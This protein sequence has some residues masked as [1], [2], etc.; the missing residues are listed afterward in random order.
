MSRIEEYGKVNPHRLTEEQLA[1]LEQEILH[2][3]KRLISDEYLDYRFWCRGLPSRQECFAACLKEKYLPPR[4]RRILEVG[5]GR[6][7]GLSRLLKEMGHRMTCMDPRAEPME[8][9]EIEVRK[10][11]FLFESA[12]LKDFD[13][14]VAQEPC[15]GT[16]HI[17]RACISQRVPFVIVLCGVPHEKIGGGM[18]GDVYEWYA[19]LAGIAPAHTELEY[20]EMY[21]EMGVAVIRSEGL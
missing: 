17:V 11:A 4:K 14:V 6:Y 21:P 8:D 16:E 3:R 20:V 13:Y 10:E 7:A 2:P 9:G 5:C 19:Y 15:D 12:D 1:V 18:P